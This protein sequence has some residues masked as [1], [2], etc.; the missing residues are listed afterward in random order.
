[1]MSISYLPSPMEPD[2]R[3]CLARDNVVGERMLLVVNE[4]AAPHTSLFLCFILF[5]KFPSV[6][7]THAMIAT[8]KPFNA[9]ASLHEIF[10]N[11]LE[12]QIA[13]LLP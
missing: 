13:D 10:G 9:L 12:L 8:A 2:A 5:R 7:T 4:D 6:T 11:M 3:I 1:M